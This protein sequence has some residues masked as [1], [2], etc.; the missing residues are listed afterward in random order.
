MKRGAVLDNAKQCVTADRAAEHGD[1]ED[2][3]AVIASYWSIHLGHKVEPVDVGVMMALLKAARAKS[4]PYHEDNYIDGAGYFA[5]SAEC[6]D[7]SD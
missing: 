5:C 3:F 6:V 2:N 4:N 7:V 1:M